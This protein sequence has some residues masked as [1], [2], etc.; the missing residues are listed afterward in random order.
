[1]GIWVWV[2]PGYRIWKVISNYQNGTI[3][4]YN[5]NGDVILD[6]RGLTR[7]V[8]SIIEANFFDKVATRV[9]D[10]ESGNSYSLINEKTMDLDNPM[11]V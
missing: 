2:Q 7:E 6:K 11:Y 3:R 4:V 8:I 5:E 1:M 9:S 10:H